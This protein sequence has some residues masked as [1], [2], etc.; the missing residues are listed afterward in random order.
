MTTATMQP[1]QV[2]SSYKEQLDSF[3][4]RFNNKEEPQLRRNNPK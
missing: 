2:N 3:I 4:N 1:Q